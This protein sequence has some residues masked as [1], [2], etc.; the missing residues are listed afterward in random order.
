MRGVGPLTYIPAHGSTPS[1]EREPI[2]KFPLVSFL[3]DKG[4]RVCYTVDMENGKL[5][6]EQIEQ[7]VGDYVNGESLGAL[8]RQYK[9]SHSTVNW[10]VRKAGIKRRDTGRPRMH[11][12][13]A[14]RRQYLRSLK[15]EYGLPKTDFLRM[16][17]E[18]KGRCKI[19]VT[20][21]RTAKTAGDLA[22]LHVDHD[23]R[24]GKVRGLLCP[25]CN[26]GLGKFQD[27]PALLA[28]ALRYVCEARGQDI[29]TFLT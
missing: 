29:A 28:K 14:R 23:H 16:Y 18:Q 6:K 4:T 22:T 3:L 9:V 25:K 8:L 27:S 13:K 5:T 2:S 24:T 10:H 19:C 20:R 12:R 26:H 15:T 11:D 21:I 17:R 7:L 1:G